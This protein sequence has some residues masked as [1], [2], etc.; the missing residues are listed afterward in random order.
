MVYSVSSTENKSKTSGDD[1][2]LYD[3]L[4]AALS[5]TLNWFQGESGKHSSSCSEWSTL[6]FLIKMSYFKLT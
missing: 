4:L 3:S 2:S 6:G 1:S 5:D